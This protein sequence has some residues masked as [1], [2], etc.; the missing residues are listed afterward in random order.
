MANNSDSRLQGQ[1]Q[2]TLEQHQQPAAGP[3]NKQQIISELYRM[4][5]TDT[6]DHGRTQLQTRSHE[7][8]WNLRTKN[9]NSIVIRH[10]NDRSVSESSSCLSKMELF[11][12]GQQLRAT[13]GKNG[14]VPLSKHSLKGPSFKQEGCIVKVEEEKTDDESP[15]PSPGKLSGPVHHPQFRISKIIQLPQAREPLGSTMTSFKPRQSHSPSIMGELS[16]T[17]PGKL[18]EAK[19][20][21]MEQ[22]FNKDMIKNLKKFRKYKGINSKHEGI[23][24]EKMQIIGQQQI[25][26]S[27]MRKR[28]GMAGQSRVETELEKELSFKK[29]DQS[30]WR[31]QQ[32]RRRSSLKTPS[33]ILGQQQPPTPAPAEAADAELLKN[34]NLSFEQGRK[35]LLR[36]QEPDLTEGAE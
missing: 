4:F 32:A 14:V 11:P 2:G 34:L 25:L 8:S 1:V 3:E 30:P 35:T 22:A 13:L 16:V 12:K 21:R 15:V 20:A 19:K 27:H 36:S 26:Q 24:G 29:E 33:T 5:K 23:F 10:P 18:S 31:S 9:K 17:G 28:E 7:N 6:Q